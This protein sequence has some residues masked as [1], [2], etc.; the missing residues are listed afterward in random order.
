[1]YACINIHTH[2]YI[3]FSRRVDSEL[4]KQ[5]ISLYYINHEINSAETGIRFY[6]Q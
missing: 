2:T 6:T 4:R 1:M 3:M 5:S